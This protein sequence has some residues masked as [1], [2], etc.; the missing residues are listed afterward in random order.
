MNNVN[1]KL[2]L[3]IF[4]F[5]RPYLFKN[6]LTIIKRNVQSLGL[7]RTARVAHGPSVEPNSKL[8]K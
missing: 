7:R 6:K 4:L 8:W 5:S 3:N 1:V 2:V